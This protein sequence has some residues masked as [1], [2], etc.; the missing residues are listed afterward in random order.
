MNGLE[1]LHL[2]RSRFRER[3]AREDGEEEEK[4][5]REEEER[6]EDPE[7]KAW[8]AILFAVSI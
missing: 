4:E 6:E 1:R 7:E 3:K 5:W 8:L 2:P